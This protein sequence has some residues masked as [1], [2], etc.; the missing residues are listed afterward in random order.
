M[1]LD[2]M[3]ALEARIRTLVDLVQ[4][5]KGRISQLEQELRAVKDRLV[6]QAELNRQ[7]EEER[8]DIRLR[9]EKVLG[10]LEFFEYLEDPGRSKEVALD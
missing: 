8:T 5:D 10:E 6:K 9:I 1:A 7:W 2:Q 3:T 4:Q